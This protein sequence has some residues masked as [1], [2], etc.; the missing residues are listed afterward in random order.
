MDISK[1]T[2]NM[3]HKT[4]TTR[5][6]FLLLMLLLAGSVGCAVPC[7]LRPAFQDAH[8]ADPVRLRTFLADMPKG[9]DLHH[10]LSGTIYAED[11]VR[12]A[13]KAGLC[14]D[15]ENEYTISA[16]P[17]RDGKVPAEKALS[18]AN[19]WNNALNSFSTRDRRN[20]SFMWGHDHFFAAFDKFDKAEIRGAMLAEAARMAARDNVMYVETLLTLFPDDLYKI[21][22]NIKKPLAQRDLEKA[23]LTLAEADLFDSKHVAEVN[24]KIA[25]FEKERSRILKD[26]P[27]SNVEI[28]YINEAIRVLPREIVFAQIAFAFALAGEN[29]RVLGLN[30]VGPEDHPL[31]LSDYELH[32]D[33][34]D[35]M[36]RLYENDT[37]RQKK[38]EHMHIALHAGELTLGLVEPENLANHIRLAVEKGHAERIGH[39]VD[40]A[41]EDRP[42]ALMNDMREKEI[43]VST[44]LTSNDIILNLSGDRHPLNL[45]REHGVPVVL[46]TD[47]MGVARSDLT[48]E[49]MR[50]FMEQGLGY[51]ELKN[52]SR[53]SLQYSFLPG[54][55]LWADYQ[56]KIITPVCGNED[57]SRPGKACI[58]FLET[59][60]KAAAQWEHERRLKL[61]EKKWF[62]N[63]TSD[64]N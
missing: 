9:A 1:E 53:N 37:H 17:C 56:S 47:D 42:Y 32:M 29:P 35:F 15:K 49:Y 6:G 60:A 23:Y 52:V 31:A 48:N 58:T 51:K 44:L 34:I 30:L 4:K 43:A 57:I 62:Y 5:F 26:G 11:Y 14:L 38:L 8:K 21:A 27:G 46:S 22:Q 36:Y 28:R 45:Y 19:L 50:A 59:N 41:Y 12:W 63:V 18:D 25:A 61:F 7:G 33:M 64:H 2:I 10:H 13:A 54:E 40:I 16:P 55:S 3:N 39:G 20:D 24:E